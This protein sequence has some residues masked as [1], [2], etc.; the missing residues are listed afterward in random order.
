MYLVVANPAGQLAVARNNT[1]SANLQAIRLALGQY[2]SDQGNETFSCASAGPLPTTTTII[3]ST[4]GYNLA[5][6][7]LP[8]YVPI[9]PVDPSASSAAYVSTANYDSDYTIMRNASG[10]ITLSAP[11]AELKQT[12]STTF[13]F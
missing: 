2:I 8:N 12:I 13:A 1:R 4:G 5:A 3:E 6:C 11:N 9:F 7:L 10:S